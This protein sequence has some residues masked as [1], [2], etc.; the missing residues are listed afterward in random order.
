MLE[1]TAFLSS[2]P[3]PPSSKSAQAGGGLLMVSLSD[4]PSLVIFYSEVLVIILGPPG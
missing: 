4:L 2:W 3:L 1:A